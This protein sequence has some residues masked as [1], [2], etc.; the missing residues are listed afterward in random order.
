MLNVISMNPR[1]CLN[2][3]IL[4]KLNSRVLII[5]SIKLM[6]FVYI[7]VCISNLITSSWQ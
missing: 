6:D 3:I 4:L 7:Y 1:V 2:C 5:C